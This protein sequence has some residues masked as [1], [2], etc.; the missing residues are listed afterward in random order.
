MRTAGKWRLLGIAAALLTTITGPRDAAAD[1]A[2]KDEPPITQSDRA[3]W[4]F[5]RLARPAVPHAGDTS[6]P[7]NDIDEF[8]LASL[9][10]S[11]LDPS[12]EAD[13]RALLRRVTLD[14]TGLPPTPREVEQFLADKEPDAFERV[15][16][17]LLASPAYGERWAQHWLDLARFAETDGFEHD[18]VRPE[19]W[20]YR[21]WVIKALNSDMPYSEFVRLQIAGDLIRPGDESAAIATGF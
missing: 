7:R 2:A 13:R 3:H 20:K 8:I 15:I 21:D 12:P 4:A 14:L 16:D 11:G 19:A 17:R 1:E 9:R 10:E 5:Q 18:H 6:W